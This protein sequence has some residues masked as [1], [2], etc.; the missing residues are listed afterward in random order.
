MTDIH[1]AIGRVQLTKVGGWTAQRQAE[2]RVPRRPTSRASRRRRSPTGAVHVYHQY[3][4]RVPEDRDGFAAALREEYNVG[5][6]RVLP[7]A[8]TTACPSV[9]RA[10]E[11]LPETENGGRA[12]CLSLPVHPSLSQDDLERIVAAV[13]AARQGG[14]LMA[15]LRAGLIGLGMMGRHHARVLARARRRRPR[16]G[17]RPGRRPARRR[18]RADRLSRTSR[19]S[20]RAGIDYCGRRRADGLHEEV[21]LALAEAGVHTLVEK[22]LAPGHRRAASGWPRRSRPRAWS[23]RSATSS[24]STPRCSRPAAAARGR[25]ARRRLPDRHPPP[26]PVPGP[27]R[28]RRRGQGPR[29]ARHRPDRLGRPEPFTVGLRAHGTTSRGRE[30]EDMVAVVGQLEQRR[31]SPT[32]WST[33]CPR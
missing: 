10:T 28:R 33:G 21:G 3:T 25:R 13:N 8:R 23:A 11:D 17:R 29:H 18:R 26:G 2:R 7:G 4:I 27:H 19:S 15:N 30:H 22:P 31:R 6:R 1:A 14:R 32:T 24:A 5:T 16:R 9:R 20:S 12:R